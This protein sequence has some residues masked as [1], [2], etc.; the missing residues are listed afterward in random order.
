MLKQINVLVVDD[1]STMRRLIKKILTDMGAET[2]FEA[3]NGAN[4]LEVLKREKIDL[5]ICDWNMPGM[6][7]VVLLERVRNDERFADIPF[8]MVTAEGKKDNILEATRRGV[9]GYVTKPFGAEALRSKIK[10][11]F[12]NGH[13]ENK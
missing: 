5:V 10:A 4:A 12:G 3:E 2:I 11:M 6:T 1:F 13:G 7:G 8:I 9:T